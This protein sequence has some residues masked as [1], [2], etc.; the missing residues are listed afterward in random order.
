MKNKLIR[1]LIGIATTSMLVTGTVPMGVYAQNLEYVNT[2]V[3]E[4]APVTE[5]PV[6]AEPEVTPAPADEVTPEATPAPSEEVVPEA[7]PSPST[8]PTASPSTTPNPY[9][10]NG[11]YEENGNKYWYENGVRQ[12]LQGRG[13]EIY[14]PGTNAW[15]WLDSNNQGAMAKSKEVYQDSNGGKWVRYDEQGHMIKGWYETKDVNG[16]AIY[17]YYD[18]ITG[19]MLYGDQVI[20]GQICAF[21]P[22]NGIALDCQWKEI[23]KLKFWYE[24]GVRQGLEG[25][26]KE[27]YDPASNEW[28]W[29]DSI[30]MGAMAVSKDVY[31]E[32][33]GGK[34]VRYDADGKMVKGHNV[35]NNY[36][37]YFDLVTG[38]MAK[39]WLK[40]AN[41]KGG[42]D[43]YYFDPTTGGR[44][45]GLAVIN[46]QYCAFDTKTGIGL[47]KTWREDNNKKYWY[48]DGVRQGTTGDGIEIFD[49]NA[50]LPSD[51]KG[52]PSGAY[53]FLNGKDGGAMAKNLVVRLA[54]TGGTKTVRYGDNGQRV[55]GWFTV[56]EN[57]GTQ[58]RY[59]Y[60]LTTGAMF[61]GKH[62]I[63]GL[64]Y[65]FDSQTGKLLR[66]DED[67]P[68]NYSWE[69]VEKTYKD[70]TG[71]IKYIETTEYD[72]KNRVTREISKYEN[73]NIIS[74]VTYAYDNASNM[75]NETHYNNRSV[76]VKSYEWKYDSANRKIEEKYTDRQ[77]SNN[78]Y[79][80]QYTYRNDGQTDK[81]EIYDLNMTKKGSFA[82]F[83]NSNGKLIQKN[84]L[85]ASDQLMNWYEYKYDARFNMTEETHYQ[86]KD[87][88][89]QNSRE[90]LYRHVYTY[91]NAGN[92]T[93][94]AEYGSGNTMVQ[95]TNYSY[96]TVEGH[97]Y[98]KRVMTYAA[99]GHVVKGYEYVRSGA[100]V[101]SYIEYG[102]NNKTNYVINYD[103]SI[104]PVDRT[105]KSHTKEDKKYVNNVLNEIIE[106]KYQL[107]MYEG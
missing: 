28:Y 7:E 33:N 34:W 51:E 17:Y 44:Y 25:R 22:D 106:T 72:Q 102:E 30:Q 27:I 90:L 99:D 3:S 32:S 57:N 20:N 40:L 87:V 94:F 41:D 73:G 23:N 70:A 11:W 16:R 93:D 48:V 59:Y 74:V 13:K 78:S 81:I 21:D 9:P 1:C 107:M 10:V 14:D 54:I 36:Y 77:N 88:S 52:H 98:E 82:F 75:I 49:P 62:V 96:Y 15:Y 86:L 45:H 63:D 42:Y 76:T 60:D 29:L 46:G 2:Q 37:Y 67:N 43:V 95:H 31:Q 103:T 71:K 97:A 61:T 53:Y 84:R 64:E 83:Y 85:N 89:N 4:E 38:A 55:H 8:A 100:T 12:G 47:N 26:G 6:V 92:V 91:D 18:L 101:V 68:I 24:K 50:L 58:S 80:E 105:I 104:F 69:P 5:E 19:A 56:T 66:S 79:I 65:E 35:L 39:G